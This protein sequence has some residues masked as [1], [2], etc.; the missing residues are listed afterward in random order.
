MMEKLVLQV[1]RDRQPKLPQKDHESLITSFYF[2]ITVTSYQTSQ[3]NI[4]IQI[5]FMSQ[6]VRRE[7]LYLT[8]ALV[9]VR[10]KIK[11]AN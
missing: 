10:N 3:L 2:K 1:G 7:S 5:N 6:Q 9:M 11:I 8:L 4:M